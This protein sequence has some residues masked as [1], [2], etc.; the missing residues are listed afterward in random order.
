MR[1]QTAFSF[2]RARRPLVASRMRLPYA[3]APMSL[4]RPLQ[5]GLA[6]VVAGTLVLSV[7]AQGPG[8]PLGDQPAERVLRLTLEDA[9]ALA[10]RNNLD[11]EIERLA[12]EAARYDEQ[13]S[14]GAFDP[15][16]DVTGSARKSENEQTSFFSGADV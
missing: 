3:L 1:K 5:T 14:W 7:S 11:L 9:L 15:V 10:L 16:L 2:R 4:L 6:I 12:T 8:T 13:A